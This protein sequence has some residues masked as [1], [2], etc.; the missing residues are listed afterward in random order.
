M[1]GAKPPTASVLLR[2]NSSYCLHA[3]IDI[4]QGSKRNELEIVTVDN[5]IELDKMVDNEYIEIQDI[6][7]VTLNASNQPERLKKERVVN[8]YVGYESY[9]AVAVWHSEEIK[10]NSDVYIFEV[11]DGS[12]YIHSFT[13]RHESSLHNFS[14]LYSYS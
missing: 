10:I 9:M 2:S 11:E 14:E 8:I 5:I 4:S 1:Q 3:V 7:L 12:R 13:G 6:Y